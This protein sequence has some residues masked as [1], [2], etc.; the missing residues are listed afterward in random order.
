M[1]YVFLIKKL[2]KARLL[3]GCHLKTV[4]VMFFFSSENLDYLIDNYTIFSV[5]HSFCRFLLSLTRFKK[6]FS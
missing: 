4:G 1:T 2:N 6:K 5:T 3:I